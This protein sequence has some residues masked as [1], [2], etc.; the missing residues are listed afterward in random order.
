MMRGI[1]LSP[2]PL[3]ALRPGQYNARVAPPWI[4]FD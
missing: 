1:E 4:V 2:V 3:L